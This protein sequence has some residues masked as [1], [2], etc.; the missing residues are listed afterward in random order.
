MESGGAREA[1]AAAPLLSSPPAPE[2]ALWTVF[3]VGQREPRRT[4]HPHLL[5]IIIM[6]VSAVYGPIA[7]AMLGSS[8]S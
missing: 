5:C 2:T 6:T 3:E 4:D 8:Y 1:G 7:P